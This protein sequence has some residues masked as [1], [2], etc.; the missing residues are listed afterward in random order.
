MAPTDTTV[1][2]TDTV[3]PLSLVPFTDI[4][5]VSSKNDYINK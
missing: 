3:V 2:P 5:Q 4:S 1:A